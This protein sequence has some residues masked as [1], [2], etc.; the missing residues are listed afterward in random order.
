MCLVS[1]YILPNL[2]QLRYPTLIQLALLLLSHI[3]LH[4]LWLATSFFGMFHTLYYHFNFLV[5]ICLEW[6]HVTESSGV[7]VMYDGVVSS[8]SPADVTY[9]LGKA[10]QMG[11]Y[12]KTSCTISL[13]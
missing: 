5:S 11:S 6:A 13:S 4:Q 7:R 1:P 2:S 8:G 12:Y 9:V 3:Q 10:A